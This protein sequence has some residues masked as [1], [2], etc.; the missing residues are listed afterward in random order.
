MK[1][2]LYLALL[3]G[4][5]PFQMTLLDVASIGG[6]RPDLCLVAA[7]LVGLFAGEWKGL[8]FGLALG[9]I[10]DQFSAGDLWMNLVAKG[11]AGFLAGGASR[12]V[13]NASTVTALVVLL[14]LSL[15]LGIP[16][17]LTGLG[18]EGW[19]G[20]FYRVRAV[21]FPEAVYNAAVGAGV[22]WLIARRLRSEQGDTGPPDFLWSLK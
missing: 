6:V 5:V 13:A 19:V 15:L 22:Y 21:L 11:G 10:Q 8:F 20:W 3:V 17:L 4:L 2:A 14:G 12:F 7:I 9:F 16:I 1:P 18:D